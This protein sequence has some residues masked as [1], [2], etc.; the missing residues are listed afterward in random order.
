MTTAS[1]PTPTRVYVFLMTGVFAASL[2]AIFIRFAINDG[3]PS[4]FIAAGRLTLSAL[5]LTPFALRSHRVELRG[6][7]RT[8]LLLA[9]ASGLI[10]AIHFAT[11]VAS[12]EYTSVLISVVLVGTSP[13][14]SALFEVV[15]LR[16][17]LHRWV[18]I[19][20]IAAF[21]GGLIISLANGGTSSAPESG[22]LLGAVLS[23]VGAVAFAIYLVIGRKLR[24]KLSLMPYIWLV[25]GFAAIFLLMMSFGTGTPVTGYTPRAYLMIVLLAL[26]PQ[27][28]GHTSFNY[29]LRYLSA[30]FV[31]IATQVEPIGS[32]FAAY[33]IFTEVPLPMQLLGSAAVLVGVMVA[34][35]G[36]G[37]QEEPKPKLE[38]VELN[39]EL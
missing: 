15:F 24:S 31:G 12:L 29:S 8:D 23:L 25:Y 26:V 13:L 16:T 32:A 37:K 2:A 36:Q 14:W 11:W 7:R 5:I 20:L 9:A 35:V 21:F 10:L 34:T 38:E 27:L 18:V 28:I 30:T 3:M 1:S 4:I 17:H 39:D 19:G 33:L 22:A 6:L